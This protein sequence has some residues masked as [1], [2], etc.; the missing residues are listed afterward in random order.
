MGLK[1]TQDLVNLISHLT[2]LQRG[3]G[4]GS[5]FVSLGYTLH[6][7]PAWDLDLSAGP[8]LKYWDYDMESHGLR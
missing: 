8:G 2:A 7:A 1:G 5:H 4:L 3:P 6:W